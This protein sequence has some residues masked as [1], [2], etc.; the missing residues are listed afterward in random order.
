MQFVIPTTRFSEK[1]ESAVAA[2][3][4]TASDK[5]IPPRLNAGSE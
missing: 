2:S 4:R 3:T 1:E 5:Q